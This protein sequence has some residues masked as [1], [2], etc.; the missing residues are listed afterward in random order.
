MRPDAFSTHH[1][2]VTLVFFAGVIVLCVLVQQPVLQAVGFAG[3]A[4]YYLCL[5]GRDAWRLLL[6]LVA[7]FV[8][9]TAIN[10]LFD[11]LGDTVLFTYLGGRP[12]T[13]EALAYGASTACMFASVMA[14]FACY[15]RVMSTDKFTYLFGNRAPALT[16]VLTMTLRLVPAYGRKARQISTARRCAGLS[17]GAGSLRRRA[18]DGASLLSALTT[19][20]LEGAVMTADSMRSRGYGTNAERE[21]QDF[22]TAR[23]TAASLEMTEEGAVPTGMTEGNAGRRPRY[24]R[25]RFGARD[26]LLL[27]VMLAC[28]A[29]TCTALA[30]GAL[31]VTYVPAIDIPALPPLGVAALVALAVLVLVPSAIDAREAIAWRCSLS[32][33]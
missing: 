18:R 19:W 27:A 20:A 10:P 11:T 26:G 16:L 24:A 8:V 5:R 25:Y 9:L 1:P 29:V 12:Y 3:G 14:W 17:M 32:S 28:I 2:A 33:T 23:P 21:G 15:A 4:V 6:G 30:T 22:S 31:A 7:A 13:L